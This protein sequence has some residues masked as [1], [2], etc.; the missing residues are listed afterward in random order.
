M[1]ETIKKIVQCIT[2]PRLLLCV[3]IAWIITN[4]WSY[5]AFGLGT[6]FEIGWLAGIAGTYLT[7]LWLPISPEKIV[8]FAIAIALLRKL[9]PNDRKTLAVLKQ[10]Y[11]KAKD[12]FKMRRDK[13][14]KAKAGSETIPDTENKEDV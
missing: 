4:G 8:T 6:Y 9:F 13:K 1:K 7:F 2:N 10:L 11:A 12:A 3:A 5:I 14:K